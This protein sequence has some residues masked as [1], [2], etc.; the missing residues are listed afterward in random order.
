MLR[1]IAMR[2]SI[3]LIARD[4]HKRRSMAISCADEKVNTDRRFHLELLMGLLPRERGCELFVGVPE[5]RTTG[6]GAFRV[7]PIQSRAFHLVQIFSNCVHE[8]LPLT[9]N[10]QQNEEK[11][12]R[13]ARNEENT[14]STEGR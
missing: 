1:L 5:R 8:P 14:G 13:F 12:S 2:S 11:I 9:T 6:D 4:A 10:L 7:L 3:L